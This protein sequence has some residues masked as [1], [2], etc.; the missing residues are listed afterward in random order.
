LRS[1][2]ADGVTARGPG[3]PRAASGMTLT[4]TYSYRSI[5]PADRPQTA[6][7]GSCPHNCGQLPELAPTGRLPCCSIC[8]CYLGH[9]CRSRVS[10][11]HLQQP[12]SHICV[13][14][15]PVL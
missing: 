15:H 5:A 13:R 12:G 10:R 8:V 9:C 6:S 3:G 4:T 11:R 2:S 7:G 14:V 1:L